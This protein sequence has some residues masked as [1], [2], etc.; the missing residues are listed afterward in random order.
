MQVKLLSSTPN[1]TE[2]IFA[3]ARQCYSEGYIGDC[4]LDKG[5]RVYISKGTNEE[6]LD[7]TDDEM[8]KL[9]THVLSSGH[10]SVLEHVQ[11]T[12][13]IEGVSRALTHQLVRHRLFS[14]SCD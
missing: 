1:P 9:I 3:S 11:F 7:Y 10:T 13:A 5:D 6:D 4:W 14:Y 8:N 12:F 2:L